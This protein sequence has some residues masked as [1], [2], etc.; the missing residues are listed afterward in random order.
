MVFSWHHL[1]EPGLGRVV[2]AMVAA[3]EVDRASP[4]GARGEFGGKKKS[5]N[6]PIENSLYVHS[7]PVYH[8]TLPILKTPFR[9]PCLL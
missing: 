2:M 3:T 7:L 5:F 8:I 1:F 6:L 4:G 9:G